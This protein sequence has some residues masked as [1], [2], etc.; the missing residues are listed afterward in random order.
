[1]FINCIKELKKNYVKILE[2]L[3]RAKNLFENYKKKSIEVTGSPRKLDLKKYNSLKQTLQR[4]RDKLKETRKSLPISD[5]QLLEFQE[6]IEK[7]LD[8]EKASLVIEKSVKDQEIDKTLL[9]KIKELANLKEKLK[10]ASVSCR[11]DKKYDSLRKWISR[12]KKSNSNKNFNV[13]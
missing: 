4:R 7:L 8:S 11:D 6:E 3:T 12:R 1:M 9:E 5:Q 2:E 10:K 13:V